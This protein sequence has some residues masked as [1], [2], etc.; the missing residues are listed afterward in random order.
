MH[1]SEVCRAALD[2]SA[3]H[4]GSHAFAGLLLLALAMFATGLGAWAW[5]LP[6]PVPDGT[7]RTG[8][9]ARHAG[10]LA[11]AIG[12]AAIAFAAIAHGV[13]HGG[14]FLAVDRA[15]SAA[16]HASVSAPALQAFEWI[17]WLGNGTVLAVLCAI[18]AAML[19]ARGER[20]LAIGVVLAIGGNGVLNAALKRIFER[21]RPPE[22]GV[23]QQFHGWSFPSG[24]AAGAMVAYGFLGYLALRLLPPRLHAPCLAIAAAL[25]LLVGAS[26]VFLAAHYA[27][28][29]LAGFASGTAWLLACIL[30]VEHFE[31]LPRHSGGAKASPL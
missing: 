5:H 27:S 18:V 3:C 4:A 25:V 31:A 15:F 10:A 13:T 6:A 24:H 2:A 1:L 11:A 9:S 17:S 19:A 30:V 7:A 29:V 21:A 14:Q 23:L 22:D 12:V 20:L 16:A 8:E 28:D 26:R